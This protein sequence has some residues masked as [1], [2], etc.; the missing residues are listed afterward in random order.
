MKQKMSAAVITLM[1]LTLLVYT[2]SRT[3]N[4]IRL[5][6]PPTSQDTAYLALVAFDGGLVLWTLF[7]LHGARGP[8]QRG[9]SALMVVVSLIAVLLGFGADT[10]YTASGYGLAHM[11]AGDAQSAIYAMVAIIGLNV[12]AV[13]FVHMTSPEA[14]LAQ[15]EEEARDKIT[16]ATLERIGQNATQLASEV[17]PQ[18]AADWQSRTRRQHLDGIMPAIQTAPVEPESRRAALDPSRLNAAVSQPEPEIAP[19][20]AKRNGHPNA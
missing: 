20:I 1:A 10:V 19:A 17:A 7:Y 13:T 8:W 11:S 15:A 12:A 5:T 18:L 16:S 6:L 9:I 2:A 14:L 4:F 3:L